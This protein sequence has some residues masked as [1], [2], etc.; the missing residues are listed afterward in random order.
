MTADPPSERPLTWGFSADLTVLNAPEFRLG[1]APLDLTRKRSQVQTLSRPP[2]FSQLTALPAP[3][4]SRSL[5]GWA[6]LGPH[7]H[8]LPPSSLTLEA[9]PLGA[10]G[11]TTTT[12]RGR[13]SRPRSA[14]GDERPRPGWSPWSVSSRARPAPQP[15]RNP[16]QLRDPRAARSPRSTHDLRS[17]AYVQASA[18]V[19]RAARAPGRPHGTR[20][21]P[22][23]KAP[24]GRRAP[25]GHGGLTRD[26]TDATGRTGGTRRPDRSVLDD[27]AR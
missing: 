7:G 3:S 6:A 22:A 19:D 25:K 8:P 21:T 12:E 16:V 13:A 11:S 5:P 14:A 1:N 26:G 17:V 4:R 18:A 2:P 20:S 24:A 9:N 10:S 27:G 15:E 23:V